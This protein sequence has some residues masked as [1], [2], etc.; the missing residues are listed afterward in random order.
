[1]G[2]VETPVERRLETAYACRSQRKSVN[3]PL[4]VPQI[5]LAFAKALELI[6]SG[7]DGELRDDPVTRTL[8]AT[9]ASLYEVLPVAVAFP[10]T[11]ADVQRIVRIAGMFGLA[12]TP[13]GA[14]T[15]LA[16]Q[17]VGPGIVLDLG[18]YMNR[19][20]DVDVDARTVRVEP[21][22]IRDDLNRAL[23]THGLFFAPETSTSNRCMIGGM[24]GNNSCGANSIRY[25][26]TRE[27]VRALSVVFSDGESH[28]L[29]PL[30]AQE[31][32]DRSLRLDALAGGM[33]VLEKLVGEHG[34]A[35]L[36]AYPKAEVR[37]RNTG[38]PLDDL[39]GS[40]LGSGG[41]PANLARF[42]CGTEGTLGVA[43]EI[44]L[45]LEP[46]PK[47]KALV[48]SHF[49]S[50]RESM[51]A[52]VAAVAH[53]PTAVELMDKRILDLSAL[54]AEQDRNRWFLEGDPGALLIIEVHGEN[55]SEADRKAE[56][57]VADLTKQGLGYAH[58]SIPP[59]RANS[60]WELRKAGLGVLFGMPGDIKPITIVEDTAVAVEDLPAFI[61]EFI[62][63]MA[64]HQAAC[65]YYGHASVGELHLRPELNPKDASDVQKAELIAGD[66]ADLVRKYRGSISGEHGD[67]RLR[68]PFIARSMTEE[69]PGWLAEIKHGFDPR[70]TFNPG[71]IVDPA[72]MTDDWRYDETYQD[73]SFDTEFGY[74][75]SGGFQR[76]VERCN[77]A[78]VCRRSADS[79]G[80]MCPSYMATSE[81]RESTR[82]R[83]NLFRRLIQQGPEAL[84]GS[85]ELYDAL[86]L[87]LACKGCKSDCPA[88]V[89][90][91][92]LKAELMQGRIDRKGAGFRARAFAASTQWSALAQKIPGG[93]FIANVAQQVP[94]MSWVGAAVLGIAR[95]RTP[96]SIAPRSFHAIA[97]SSLGAGPAE[98]LGTVCLYVDEFTDRF[99]PE[100]GLAA[101]ELLHAGGYAVVAPKLGPSGR[102]YLSKGF[103][104]EARE[105]IRHNLRILSALPNIDAIVGIEPSA[106]LTLLDEGI[107]LLKDESERVSATALAS[108]TQ[109]VSD[110]VAAA[111]ASGAWN[112]KW[113]DT[114]QEIHLHGHCHQKAQVG[115][116]GTANALALPE[117]YTVSV[118]PSG[119]CGMAGS[120][121]YEAEHYDVSMEIGELVLF[122]AVRDAASATI[123]A[124]PGT[125]CRHQ[126]HDGTKRSAVHPIQ[127]LRDA[128]QN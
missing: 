22:V 111:A 5:P 103:V 80:T 23:A 124:A 40:H 109:L 117:N 82:G 38:F 102:T 115:V 88:S 99:E 26:T 126:I 39:L 32:A 55:Q 110:F 58:V 28:D 50:V 76:A 113:T 52:T 36:N 125:S 19:I 35:I 92:T 62:E 15:S 91:A 93:A 51:R 77:G 24:V 43:T 46:L 56:T 74:A 53:N 73:T 6:R 11:A 104:R 96:P 68:S 44:V 79:G 7:I 17:A 63:I 31:W 30:N 106:V 120:F 81:E 94:P 60:V 59:T 128:L 37:R 10:K 49:E 95:K 34:D 72:P 90:M 29:G 57:L 112:G 48:A 85:D 65:V 25:E 105:H 20:L 89:D 18:R 119:C 16:G 101:V 14:G 61:D 123:I 86:D 114:V 45:N 118:I 83:A 121:G 67:G 8:F 78:G 4:K 84:F 75:T 27:H 64:T 54:N 41:A 3:S 108:K 87:C 69:V 70:G 127:I 33:K 21:G 13:R 2:G 1:M 107:D 97:A 116:E 100:I 66:V 98:P 122:P 42:F 12:V 9:D 47:A 71:N